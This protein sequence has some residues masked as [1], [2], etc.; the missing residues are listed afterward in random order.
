MK[1]L[2]EFRDRR[3]AEAI[4]ARIR[5]E[6]DRPVR[7]MEVCGT[8]TVSIFRSGLRQLLPPEISLL[9]GPGCPVCVTSQRDVDYAIELASQPGVILATYGD[10][11]KV[12]GTRSSL[13]KERAAGRDIR[14]VYSAADAVQ[15]AADNPTRQV[16]LLAVGFE[17]TTPT[18]AMSVLEA[19]ERGLR[20]FRIFSAHKVIGPPLRALLDSREVQLD[21]FILP[22]HVSAVI[23]AKPYQFMVDDYKMPGVIAGFEPLDVLQTVHMLIAQVREGRPAIEIQY[24]RV[25]RPEGN[26]VAQDVVARVF[27]P[28]DAVWRGL[29]AIP[30][31]GLRLREEYA[32]FDAERAF[33]FDIDVSYSQEPKGCRCGDVLRGVMTPSQ[34]PLFAKAC[35]P[36]TAIGPCMVSSEGTCA[37]YYRYAR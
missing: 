24:R 26:P 27:E 7:F 22:G 25:V 20:N 11:M 16:V 5:V 2:D 29:G 31:S 1:Y 10:M 30:Q 19:S 8:H 9:S 28:A 4:L 6:C 14:I 34:C 13:L 3:L 36:E 33:D 23:G 21:G 12:A 37:A 32:A 15:M 35:T 17:T 18:A